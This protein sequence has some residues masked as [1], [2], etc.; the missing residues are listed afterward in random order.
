M[1]SVV[2]PA[3]NS[4]S[5]IS[6]TL[7]SIYRNNF[8]SNQFEVLIVD[9]GSSDNT[10]KIAEKFPVRIYHS[11]HRGI[12]PPRNLGIKQAKGNI[13]CFTDSDCVVE[14]NWLRKI[15]DFFEQNPDAHGVGGP[16]LTYTRNQNKLQKLTGELFE[17]DQEYPVKKQKLKAGSMH[18]LIFGTNSAYDRESVLSVGGYSEPGGSNLELAWRLASMGRNLYFSP[19]IRVQHIFPW[20]LRSIMKQQYRWG[21]Q[22]TYM[23]KTHGRYQLKNEVF[24]IP[25]FLI[26]HSLYLIYLG[27]LEKRLLHIVQLTSFSFG[28]VVGRGK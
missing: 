25:Y 16:V 13:I 9:N 1:L 20:S 15:H 14:E 5:T 17:V 22:L 24:L 23:K 2:I 10:A 19:E 8:P 6:L 11:N 21:A 27:E 3:L 28:Q 18:G 7:S 26:K 12:G 4:E